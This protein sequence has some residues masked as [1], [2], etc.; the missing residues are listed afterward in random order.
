MTRILVHV[1]GPTEEAFVNEV[2]SHHLYQRGFTDVSAR[3]V[4]NA[5]ERSRRGGIVSWSI[6]RRRILS[7]LIEDPDSR[8]TTM[9]DYYALPPDW[10]GRADG[11]THGITPSQ[12]AENIEEALLADVRS[13]MD[14]NFNPNRF[15][16]YVMMHEFEAMLFSDCQALATAMGRSDL[17]ASLQAVRNEFNT[18]EEIDDS[19]E[20]APSRRIQRLMPA[21]QKPTIGVQAAQHIGLESIRNQCPHFA[22]WLH[23]LENLP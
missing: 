13:H 17:N 6:V 9:V 20:T 2:L 22:H 4:G 14:R 16:P 15:I 5:R 3:I 12:M 10:P 19:P 23:R 18:P 7:H 11:Y 21:Y 1:E 8:S